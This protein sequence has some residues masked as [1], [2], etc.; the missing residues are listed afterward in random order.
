MKKSLADRYI[1]WLRDQINVGENTRDFIFL[2]SR[3]AN[4]E[5]YALIEKDNNRAADGTYLRYRYCEDFGCD[6][7][8]LEESLGV[9]RV[10]EMMVAL[11]I[12][13]AMSI[14]YEVT[15]I[16]AGELFWMMIDNLGLKIFRDENVAKYDDPVFEIDHIL[17]VFMSRRD[18]CV[19]LFRYK[20]TKI[21]K[22]ELEIWDQMNEWIVENRYF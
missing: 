9:C 15:G 11:A 8:G 22:L 12:N 14:S 7:V 4:T 6:L 1:F 20:Y 13:G 21:K 16:G 5:F 2:L 17:H 18:E 10:L 19:M 3:L